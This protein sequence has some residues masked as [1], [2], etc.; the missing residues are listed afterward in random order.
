VNVTEADYQRILARQGKPE[1]RRTAALPCPSEAQEQEAVI[2]W[3]RCN[4]TRYPGCELLFHVPN[5]NAHHKVRQGVC[6]GVPDLLLPV[7][8]GGYHGLWLEL[9][10]AD[11]SNHPSPAQHAWLTRLEAEGY[12]CVVAYGA[13]QAIEAITQYLETRG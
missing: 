8:R 7:A 9:K 6:A 11:H 5:E 13:A 2:A 3:A 10:R 12:R 1:P 4:S